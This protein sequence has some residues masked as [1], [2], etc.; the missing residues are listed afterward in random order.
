[1]VTLP[2]SRGLRRVR[3][4]LL[5]CLA[6]AAG[7]F[8]PAAGPA[9]PAATGPRDGPDPAN[10]PNQVAVL[11]AAL[12]RQPRGSFTLEAFANAPPWWMTVSGCPQGNT[13]ATDARDNLSPDSYAAYADF[14]SQVLVAF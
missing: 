1:M 2:R 14:L 9:P 10:G 7:A 13:E 8:P 3:L 6:V 11:R 12:A 5:V 4:A